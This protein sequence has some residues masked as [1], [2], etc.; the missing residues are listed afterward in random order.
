MQIERA[1]SRYGAGE[2]RPDECNVVGFGRKS[3]F[4][5]NT[6]NGKAGGTRRKTRRRHYTPISCVASAILAVLVLSFL[7]TQPAWAS[8]V[9][10]GRA[11]WYS[12]ASTLAEGNTG[13]M[14]N[15]QQMQDTALTAAS[16]D[17]PL[18]TKVRITR[19]ADATPASAGTII[20]EITDRGPSKALYAQ[21]K[22]IDLSP[23]SF[24]ALGGTR[25]ITPAGIAW[26]E[27]DVTVERIR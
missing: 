8:E 13:V 15:G 11:T 3:C 2:T 24:D 10:V 4:Q 6:G 18:G 5:L 16:W 14:A 26:G 22:I 20:A 25:G 27:I 7:L 23:Q 1:Y 21:G 12:H 9:R 17:Y 19:T